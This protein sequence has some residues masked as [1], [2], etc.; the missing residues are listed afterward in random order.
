MERNRSF[1]AT[2]GFLVVLA[3]PRIVDAPDVLSVPG[4]ADRPSM[5]KGLPGLG[6]AR[7][8]GGRR[9]GWQM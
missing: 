8:F 3:V 6:I 2:I 4:L 5:G 7:P 1:A 9:E